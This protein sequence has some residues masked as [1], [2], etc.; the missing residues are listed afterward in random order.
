MDIVMGRI[1]EVNPVNIEEAY[2]GKVKRPA[3]PLPVLQ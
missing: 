2:K 3:G 1:L